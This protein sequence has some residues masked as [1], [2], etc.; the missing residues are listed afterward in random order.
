MNDKVAFQAVKGMNDILPAQT[1]AWQHLEQVLKE[2]VTAYGYR[3]IRFPLLEQTALFKRTIGEGTD[4][5]EKEMYTFDDHGES[6]TLRPEGTAGCVRAALEHGLLHH[7]VQR[8]W[9][10]GPMYRHEK[11][12]KDRYRQFYQFGV[13]AL[14]MAGP[15]VDAEH[16]LMMARVWQALGLA[17]KV[18]LQLNSLGSA[19]ARAQHR[20]ALVA[21][22]TQHQAA[23]DEDSRRRLTI[24]PLR[25]LDSKNP[26]LQQLIEHAPKI[27][28][29]LDA[30]SQAH[31]ENLC[32]LL[33]A[34][35]IH[36]EINPRLVRGLDYYGRTVYEWVAQTGAA[37]NTLCAGGRYDALVEQ[38][39]GASV[40]AVGFA[41]GLERILNLLVQQ[42]TIEASLDGY[43]ILAG[44]EVMQT[45]LVW[46]EKI[47]TALPQFR[48]IM[49]YEGG[50]FKSQFKRADKSG[51]TWALIMGENELATGKISLKSL[52]VDMP[53]QNFTLVELIEFLQ[54]HLISRGASHGSL[55]N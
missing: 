28:E 6:L 37:Q 42:Q 22:F 2:V 17:E 34:A 35:G 46:A 23:L 10:C 39:G 24:N 8:L 29:Y 21:Y 41:M 26:A 50:S 25:I 47:H 52:R 7:Q 33:Q 19:A 20:T 27:I 32:Q 15:A 54:S 48:F 31:F 40:P 14:G 36:Y 18:S 55:H 12:Q 44:Q 4:I 30:D 53:Q 45:S 38:L 13:E 5:V 49:D 9:Y 43:F 51:A 16:I 11:P 1:P 3:E